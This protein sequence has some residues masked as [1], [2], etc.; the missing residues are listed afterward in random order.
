MKKKLQIITNIFILTGLVMG[1]LA[2]PLNSNGQPVFKIGNYYGCSGTEVLI[3]VEFENF[4]DISAFT[5][6][7]GIDTS[8]IDYIGLENIND[9]FSSGNL[10]DGV[11]LQDQ[12]IAFNWFSLTAV[13]S[14]SGVLCNIKVLLKNN[15]VDFNFLD[16]C[17]IVKSDLSII[18]D[19]DYLDGSIK[20]MNSVEP[21]PIYQSLMD[22]SP[23]NIELVGIVGEVY[24][25]WQKTTGDQWVD[26]IDEPPYSGV[27]TYNLSIQS[28]SV[29]M[30]NT[31]YRGM[32]SNN[33]CSE[34]SKVSELAVTAS[35]LDDQFM[36][37]PMQVYPNPA[38]GYLVCFFNK[39]IQN[40]ELRLSS[41]S[42]KIVL[43]QEFEN[44][45]S[46]QKISLD[47]ESIES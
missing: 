21:N 31:L 45:V 19:V 1:L 39:N 4:D 12:Y 2:M 7:I 15:S 46:G 8:N 28:V 27:N 44:I 41:I 5:I 3:P 26:I 17:E 10:A 40:A 43:K 14:E 20:A 23:A 22:E 16:N 37:E 36:D 35:S 38:N 11:N 13:T 9:V 42:G 29:D 30:N 24:C 47:L 25:Q 32:L 18:Q 6:Y 34:G 33:I